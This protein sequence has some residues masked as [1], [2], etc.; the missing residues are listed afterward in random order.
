MIVCSALCA[1]SYFVA[2]LSPVA[3]IGLMGCALCGFF[4]GIMWP[5]TYSIAAKRW[6]NPSTALFAMFALAG[7][8]GCSTGPLLLGTVS[9]Y[10]GDNLKTGILAGTVFPLIMIFAVIALMRQDKKKTE[11]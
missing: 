3:S 4:V 5:G 11:E 10:F 8:T 2:S 6:Y 7:D 1:V 9:Q